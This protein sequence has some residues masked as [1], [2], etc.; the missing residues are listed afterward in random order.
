VAI[1]TA[2]SLGFSTVFDLIG[3]PRQPAWLVA[4]HL[5]KLHPLS[6]IEFAR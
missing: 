1:T 3:K 5:A 6:R 2:K 4:Q